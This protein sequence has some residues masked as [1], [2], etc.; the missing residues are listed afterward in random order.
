LILQDRI[1]EAIKVFQNV[2]MEQNEKEHFS[3]QLQYD[4]IAAYL[5]FSVGYPDFKIAKALCKKYKEFPLIFWRELF[6]EIEDQMIEFEGKE[7]FGDIDS[8]IDEEKKKKQATKNV[9]ATEPKLQFTVESDRTLKIIYQNI[10]KFTIKFYLIDLEILFSRTPFIKSNSDDFSFV[11]ANF[12]QVVE[13]EKSTKENIFTFQIPNE[14]ASKNLF[15]EVSSISKKAFETYFS[16]SLNC[17]ISENLGEIKITDSSFQ[18]L[19]KVYVKCFARMKD[20][21][22]KFYKDG[23]TD[24]RGKFNFISLNTD[25]LRN[26]SRFSIFVIHDQFGSLIKECNPPANIPQDSGVSDYDN[27]QNYRQEVK[28]IWRS[29][30]KK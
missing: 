19:T 26:L 10:D 13:L 18:A 29:K 3:I 2:R 23:Y 30:N 20:N 14:Y 16:T 15:I 25:D 21:S 9:V 22:V 11:L 27:Y 4:Y 5:D 24:L 1:E 8:L 7:E 28:Q 17:T 6:E 12:S